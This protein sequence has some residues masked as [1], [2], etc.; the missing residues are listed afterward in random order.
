MIR[1]NDVSVTF[2]AKQRQTRAV[3]NVSFEINR[4]EIFGIVGTSGAGKSTLLRTLNLLEQP[5]GGSIII[6]GTEMT[7][8]SPRALRAARQRMGM[9]FQHFN[10]IHTKT[11]YENIAF[12]LRIAG[13]SRAMI[14][15]RVPELLEIVGLSEKAQ[16]Y[17]G[18]LSGGQKQRVGIARAIAN[19]PRV[20]LCDEP[21][22]AL[23]LETTQA[24]LTLIRDINV[25]FGITV[26]IISH[27]MDVIKRI[28]TRVAVMNGGAVV[29]LNDVFSI[30]ADPL[31]DVTRQ[32]VRHSLNI[33]LPES[34]LK[35]LQGT[36]VRI[37]Y[38]GSSALDP[39]LSDAV[40]N[41]AVDINIL[42]GKIEYINDQPVGIL[43]VQ[44]SGK[45]EEIKNVV[46]Y[47]KARTADTEVVH[48]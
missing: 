1:F 34:V 36:V 3:R 20:L 22:S 28:C 2:T 24:I 31:H 23:D 48:E 41:H 17:P 4:G 7:A 19:K 35:G 5:T 18:Q 14:E 37:V 13:E 43:L 26:V 11:V 12:P 39:V 21:T 38:R 42:H 45:P 25:R 44:L 33:E 32:L 10:L 8:L 29:E 46:G 30:F 16:A 15:Q 9:V 40:R 27:E 6:D 47:L